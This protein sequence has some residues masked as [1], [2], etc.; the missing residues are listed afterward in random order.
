MRQAAADARREAGNAAL[1]GRRV[2]ENDLRRLAGLAPRTL[3]PSI[4]ATDT[5]PPGPYCRLLRRLAAWLPPPP[6]RA[7]P[8][9]PPSRPTS[10]SPPTPPPPPRPRR[11]PP[12]LPG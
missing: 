1:E 7:A 12:T 8:T 9:P 4:S 10:P 2:I 11:A 3:S 6:A 5:A